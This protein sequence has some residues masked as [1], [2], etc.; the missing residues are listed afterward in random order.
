MHHA[1]D[2]FNRFEDSTATPPS[3]PVRMGQIVVQDLSTGVVHGGIECFRLL[4]R[5]IPAYWPIIP[6][7]YFPLIR[8]MIENDIGGECGG[9]CDI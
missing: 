1:L 8:R 6:L 2:W 3:G 5:N 4:C 7:T 9:A